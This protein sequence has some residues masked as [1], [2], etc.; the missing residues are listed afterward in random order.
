MDTQLARRFAEPRQIITRNGYQIFGV[1]DR[2]AAV[3]EL[4][5]DENGESYI[6]C[7]D[8]EAEALTVARDWLADAAANR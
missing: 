3:I 1:F 6:G 2:S 4:F 7:A 5:L 8:T